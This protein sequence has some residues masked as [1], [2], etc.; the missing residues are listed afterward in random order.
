MS[1]DLVVQCS[2]LIEWFFWLRLRGNINYQLWS[3]CFLL[4][5]SVV[6]LCHSIEFFLK[7]EAEISFW[8][9]IELKI[10]IR[11]LL[12]PSWNPWKF[13]GWNLLRLLARRLIPEAT[14]GSFWKVAN[15]A[16]DIYFSNK[17]T[18]NL[19]CSHLILIEWY[20]TYLFLLPAVVYHHQMVW[21]L[22]LVFYLGTFRFPVETFRTKSQEPS[23]R[24]FDLQDYT[25][26]LTAVQARSKKNWEIKFVQGMVAGRCL[27]IVGMGNTL[28]SETEDNFC[29][30]CCY[31]NSSGELTLDLKKTVHKMG[32]Y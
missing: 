29:M 18:M 13:D 17:M 9:E 1:A 23:Q 20:S 26:L 30:C 25:K 24:W 12:R 11:L 16:G 32:P 31:I 14:G 5:A 19:V 21:W 2:K 8:K 7:Q 28:N 3:H 15:A 4:L 6:W 27:K 22:S 10:S